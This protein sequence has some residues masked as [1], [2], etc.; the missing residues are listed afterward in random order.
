MASKK[1][2]SIQDGLKYYKELINRAN[3]SKFVNYENIL[4]GK[5]KDNKTVVVIPDI[6]LWNAILEDPELKEN[7]TKYNENS[8][9]DLT[10]EDLVRYTSDFNSPAWIDLDTTTIY[11]GK[12][13]EL[14]VN[15]VEY[16]IPISRDCLPLKLKKAECNNL[17]YRIFGSP[18]L[19]LGI[20]KYFPFKVPGCDVTMMRMFRII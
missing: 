1:I 14:R 9:L 4:A 11:E 3:L 19:T 2:P 15:E 10:V 6:P 18:I 13:I 16:E 20:K 8:Y 17:T 7:I 12:M 5:N